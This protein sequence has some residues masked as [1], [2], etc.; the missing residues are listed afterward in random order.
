VGSTVRAVRGYMLRKAHIL[1]AGMLLIITANLIAL[2]PPYLLQEAI[3]GIRT[4]QGAGALLRYALLIVA[5]ALGAGV[6]QFCSRYV[7]NSVS[8]HVEYEIR[9]DVF[10]HFQ[11]LDLEFFQ[12]R[13][14]GDLVARAT[15]DLSAVRQ[16]LGPGVSNL[17]NA[18]VAFS[19]T[20]IAMV[21]IDPRLTLYSLTVMPLITLLFSVVGGGIRRRFRHVQ[22]QFGE[23]SARAQ[24]NFS[25]IRV[26][27]A[28]AQEQAEL[29]AFNRVN[30][31]YVV[32]SI[33]FARL[34][35]LLWP[36]MYFISGLAVAILLWRGGL[37]VI[38]GRIT[39]G[40]LVRFNAYL[41]ALTFPMISLG[42]TVNLFQQGSASL[43][44]IEEV[45][46]AQPAIRD[47]ARTRPAARPTR[48]EV[49]LRHVS[50]AY[51]EREVLHDISL[52]VPAGGSLGIVGPTGAG[53]SSLVNLIPRVYDVTAGQVLLD[54]EDVRDIPLTAVRRVIGYV[55][56]ETFLF[57]VTIA[58]NVGFGVEELDEERLAHALR[59]SQ[60]GK[61]V[62]DFPHG[63]HTMVGERGVTLS[64]GQK[65]RAGI[66]R[67]VAKEPLILI[68]DDALSSVDTNTEAAIL[69]EL[70]QVMAGRTSIV[71]AHRISAVKNLDQIVVL[72]QGRIVER[73][74]HGELLGA[75]G[76]Y[77]DMYRRQL[78]GEELEDGEE[79]EQDGYLLP[80]SA[81]LS[82]PSERPEWD[83]N[84]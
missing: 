81:D 60:L 9:T 78:L 66:A 32:R 47:T 68:L 58:E 44:R 8:R 41:T 63:A 5:V 23:V 21:Q 27:K 18:L 35:A 53:K 15:N 54:G 65:Q 82:E 57:S 50:L 79:L 67:A 80:E 45:K 12:Q 29:A 36:A 62:A 84:I 6:F 52:H 2:I 3:D 76:L 51:G 43:S 7:I 74:T 70:Q 55:P 13:K 42:W 69:R 17:C 22:D 40:R 33:A 19:V 61:D 83:G 72:D 4:G 16:M 38:S 59:V 25:G 46:T 20:G 34:N 28:Y 37:D 73:G 48:G 75:G 11:T 39:L 71:I 30:H 64:G 31:E 10:K 1:F 26:V 56:Q 49:E 14:I 24:E 77:A